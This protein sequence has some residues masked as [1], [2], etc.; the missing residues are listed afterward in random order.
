MQ[1]WLNSMVLILPALGFQKG[2]SQAE[3]D[4]DWRHVIDGMPMEQ[5]ARRSMPTVH[6][7]LSPATWSEHSLGALKSL[8]KKNCT[9]QSKFCLLVLDYISPD[10]LTIPVRAERTDSF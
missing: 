10:R 1:S 3:L 9:Q 2:N 7:T 8:R 4:S 6:H 5:W